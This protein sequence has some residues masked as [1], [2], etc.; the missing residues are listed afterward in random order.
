MTLYIALEIIHYE[1]EKIIG[2]YSTRELAIKALAACKQ[3]DG[4]KWV[5]EWQV[6]ETQLDMPLS[7][8]R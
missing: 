2:V 8:Y 4:A 6:V 5:D 7:D 3:K 1:Y